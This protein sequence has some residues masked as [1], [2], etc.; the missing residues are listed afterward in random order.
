MTPVAAPATVPVA[1]DN[2]ANP[3]GESETSET[4]NVSNS[5]WADFDTNFGAATIA[6]FES[7]V[8]MTDSE[9]PLSSGTVL[10]T[11]AVL[12]DT[13]S[14]SSNIVI[15]SYNCESECFFT[16]IRKKMYITNMEKLFF[17]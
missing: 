11:S 16:F 17:V 12:P 2:V 15:Y 5:G 6:Q 7:V 10:P 4:E 13:N 1:V 14:T 3:W 9:P 8:G